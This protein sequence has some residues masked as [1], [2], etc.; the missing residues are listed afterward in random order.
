MRHYYLPE[1]AHYL[2]G[3][4][5]DIANWEAM[6]GYQPYLPDQIL[7]RIKRCVVVDPRHLL[8][9]QRVALASGRQVFESLSPSRR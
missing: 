7:L 4:R 8:S 3:A 2:V 6:P 5:A 1:R 9:G